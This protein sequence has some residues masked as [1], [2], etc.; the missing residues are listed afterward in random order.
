[1]QQRKRKINVKAPFIWRNTCPRLEGLLAYQSLESI[2]LKDLA[3][4]SHKKQKVG[5]LVDSAE[6]LTLFLGTTFLHI[7]EAQEG[8]SNYDS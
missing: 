3:N 8:Y 5:K 1:M 7:N 2:S 4:R 6:R